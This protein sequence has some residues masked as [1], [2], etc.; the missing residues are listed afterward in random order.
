MSRERTCP[1]RVGRAHFYIR[2]SHRQ[3]A[4]I[5]MLSSKALSS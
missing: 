3:H 5:R 2:H 1:T 4:G